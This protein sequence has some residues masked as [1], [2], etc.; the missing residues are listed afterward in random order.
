MALCKGKKKYD[1]KEDKKQK[2][3][4]RDSEITIKRNLSF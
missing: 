1:K 2:D 4:K 3:I